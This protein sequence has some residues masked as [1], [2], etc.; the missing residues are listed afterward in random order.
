M[1]SRKPIHEE[2]YLGYNLQVY[3]THAKRKG[4]RVVVKWKDQVREELTMK[5]R[6]RVQHG[7][8]RTYQE[9]ARDVVHIAI[10][11]EKRRLKDSIARIEWERHPIME[12]VEFYYE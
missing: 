3:E 7:F 10:N 8:R 11:N 5:R 1:L 4:Y 9:K 12:L 2:I 6:R